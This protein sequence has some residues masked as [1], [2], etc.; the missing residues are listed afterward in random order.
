MKEIRKSVSDYLGKEGKLGV[1]QCGIH[2][3]VCWV[4]ERKD[5][6]TW[7]SLFISLSL[8]L[9]MVAGKQSAID[10]NDIKIL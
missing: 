5:Q 1:M 8:S 7:M 2:H 3:R 4:G 10:R 9:S 6:T